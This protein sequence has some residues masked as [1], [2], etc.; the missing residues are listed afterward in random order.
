MEAT[1][2]A[3]RTILAKGVLNTILGAIHIAGAFTFEARNIAAT[4]TPTLR[5][6]YLVWFAGVGV[7]ILFSGIVDLLCVRE[8]RAGSNLAWRISLFS[9]IGIGLFGTFG[10]SIHGIS[11]PLVLLATGAAATVVLLRV[12]VSF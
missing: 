6:D 9:A 12:R 4:G 1:K 3:S 8:L 2:L 10:V 5:R 7:F 11:P